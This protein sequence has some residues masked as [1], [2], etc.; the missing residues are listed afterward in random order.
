MTNG[1]KRRNPPR[2]ITSCGSIRPGAGRSAAY[3]SD[4]DEH[5]VR[6]GVNTEA[7][8]DAFRARS[9]LSSVPPAWH[10]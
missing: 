10:T 5:V 6:R 3:V 7:A 2:S 4:L 8:E 1:P 9:R